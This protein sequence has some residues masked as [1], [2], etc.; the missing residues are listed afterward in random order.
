V[1]AAAG[2]PARRMSTQAELAGRGAFLAADG[3]SCLP[4]AVVLADGG[5]A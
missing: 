5:A 4:G 2:V 1:T 3:V